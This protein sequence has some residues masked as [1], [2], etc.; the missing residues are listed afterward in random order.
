[1]TLQ[2]VTSEI[3]PEFRFHSKSGIPIGF[4]AI[5]NEV[6]DLQAVKRASARTGGAISARHS[7]DNYL[8]KRPQHGDGVGGGGGN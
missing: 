1:M 4:E 2:P 6:D 8:G 5:L 3:L 7:A